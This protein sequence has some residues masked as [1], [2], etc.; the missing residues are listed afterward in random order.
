[1][2]VLIWR[3][4]DEEAF[5][6]AVG[7]GYQMV[8]SGADLVCLGEMGIGNTTAAAAVAAALFGGG[9]ARWAGRGTGVDD[10]GL[11]RKQSTIDMGLARHAARLA[12]PLA[13]A[14]ALVWRR[15]RE[16]A[17]SAGPTAWMQAAIATDETDSAAVDQTRALGFGDRM[18]A[19][20]RVAPSA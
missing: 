8:A 3:L 15:W 12:D 1:M 5:L 2:L 10:M 13:S 20:K 17:V 14:A 16:S 11:A 6:A 19:R 18:H 4:M 7:I 9:G